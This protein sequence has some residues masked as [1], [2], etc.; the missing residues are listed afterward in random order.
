MPNLFYYS[1]QS[2]DALTVVSISS[3]DVDSLISRQ[4]VESI[5]LEVGALDDAAGLNSIKN[6]IIFDKKILPLVGVFVCVSSSVDES[7]TA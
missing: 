2:V 7:L 4:T 5:G 3:S 6:F 1:L